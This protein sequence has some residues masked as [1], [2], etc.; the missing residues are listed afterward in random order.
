MT[1]FNDLPDIPEEVTITVTDFEQLDSIIERYFPNKFFY[2]KHI[3]AAGYSTLFINGITQPISLFLLGDPSTK[4]S[5]LL[6]IMRGL[7]KA[8]FSDIFSPASFV[9]GARD[10]EG[11]DL[12][13]RL[14]NRCLVTPELGVLFKDRNL[15][16][17]L[18]MLTRLLDGFGYVRHTGFGE[19]GIHE[20]VRF[21]WCAAI[22]KIQPKI[23]DLLG[24]LGHRLLF[25]HLENEN[26]SVEAVENRLVRM[27]TEDRDY[28]EKLSI[29]R[30]AVIAFFQNIQA[31][32]PNG[33]IWNTAM[34]N[35]R[36]KQIIVRAALMLKSLRGT[37]DPKDATNTIF[38]EP[39]RLTQ[40]FYNICRGHA[41]MHYRTHIIVNDVESVL[42]IMLDSAPPERKKLLLTLLKQNG[43]IDADQYMKISK[44]DHKRVLGVFNDFEILNIAELI[45]DNSMKRIRLKPEFSWL[46]N[47]KILKMIELHN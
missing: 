35:P 30:N 16:Q 37:I 41:L 42:T 6:E 7:D 44:H 24:H 13:P 11:G 20:N 10:I 4:K 14:R 46:L 9:S 43:E 22:V 1:T 33:V 12:L 31:R 27:I 36:A 29:C 32:Y 3:L 2:L 28:I 39:T 8:L 19:V 15:P 18:G 45:Q 5:S 47:K 17:T 34:D 26:E 23:W 38:E 21:N 25:L 40:S